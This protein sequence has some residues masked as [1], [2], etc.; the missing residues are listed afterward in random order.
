ME[1]GS[2]VALISLSNSVITIGRLITEL[3]ETARKRV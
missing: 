2:H 3:T 1:I